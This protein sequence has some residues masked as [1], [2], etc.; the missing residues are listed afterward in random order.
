MIDILPSESAVKHALDQGEFVERIPTLQRSAVAI[1]V[2]D[3]G[4]AVL[5]LPDHRLVNGFIRELRNANVGRDNDLRD[6]GGVLTI[7]LKT[8]RKQF[9]AARRRY[10]MRVRHRIISHSMTDADARYIE[11]GR[12]SSLSAILIDREE[13][14]F[15]RKIV[16]E[17]E[18]FQRSRRSNERAK[19]AAERD[20][21]LPRVRRRFH[22]DWRRTLPATWRRT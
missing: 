5:V 8:A 22:G 2:N 11:L 13:A 14:A 6:A 17:L 1:N 18:Y 12:P 10:D 21:K 4:N 20:A 16:K 15:W 19:R 7:D 3:H 9:N